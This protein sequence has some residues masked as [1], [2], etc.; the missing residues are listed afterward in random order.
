VIGL[1]TLSRK[2]RKHWPGGTSRHLFS[3]RHSRCRPWERGA[4]AAAL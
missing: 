4:F 1:G 2:L 3:R